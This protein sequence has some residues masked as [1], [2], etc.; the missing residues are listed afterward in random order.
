M[1]KLRLTL[2]SLAASALFSSCGGDDFD[3][4]V[5]ID[6]NR[7]TSIPLTFT[8][9]VATDTVQFSISPDANGV[10]S[11]ATDTI[12]AGLYVARWDA[13]HALPI[14]LRSHESQRLCG[15]FQFLDSLTASNAESR[16]VIAAERLRSKLKVLTDSA[17]TAAPLSSPDGRQVVADSLTLIRQTARAQADTIL[18]ALPDSSIAALPILGL[19]GL[20]DDV[21]DNALLISRFEGMM[22][23]FPSSAFLRSR[24]DAL[25]RTARLVAVRSRLSSGCPAPDFSFMTAAGDTVSRGSLA[26]R[27][28]AI[29]LLPDSASASHSLD[30]IAYLAADGHRVLVQCAANVEL[31]KKNNVLRGRFISLTLKSDVEAFAPAVIAVSPDATISSLRLGSKA[32]SQH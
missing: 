32:R 11:F 10:Y 18:A 25:S 28:F 26:N 2:F 3:G 21:V 12:A 8:P 27:R 30:F 22:R 23:S 24:R 15:T 5:F 13:D 31:P 14:V 20:Y 19:P 7:T 9:L 1:I 17:L 16:A 29:A 4:R 6:L